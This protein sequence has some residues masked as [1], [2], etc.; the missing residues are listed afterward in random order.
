VDGAFTVTRIDDNSF[1]YLST[2]N[3]AGSIGTATERFN[4]TQIENC[5]FSGTSDSAMRRSTEYAGTY[6]K[7]VSGAES[8]G[9]AN[10][11]GISSGYFEDCVATSNSFGGISSGVFVR[12]S[13]T[14]VC[15]GGASGGIVSGSFRDCLCTTGFG[16]GNSITITGTFLNCIVTSGNGFGSQG[17]SV[18]SG[19][20]TDCSHT[21][22][23][24]Y[25]GTFTGTLRRCRFVCTGTNNT[26]LTVGS[27][28]KIFDSTLIATGTGNSITAGSAVTISLAGCRMNNSINSNVS[29][30]LGTL[31]ESYN[32]ID[33]DIT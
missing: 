5:V 13:G 20:L 24:S 21:N 16:L 28:A 6:K 32:L 1:S 2:V 9:N 8:F 15:F 3:A 23:S 27:G 25:N 7:C 22:T 26:A 11:S 10:T 33:E 18:N 29:N 17:G 14:T 4:L 31:T 30:N 12:C 19:N